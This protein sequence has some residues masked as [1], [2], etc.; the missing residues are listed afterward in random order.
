[1]TMMSHLSLS[2][3][4]IDDVSGGGLAVVRVVALDDDHRRVQ[5]RLRW[6]LRDLF[7][8]HRFP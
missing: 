5:W 2:F 4:A 1:M 7:S 8:H 6:L 3:G